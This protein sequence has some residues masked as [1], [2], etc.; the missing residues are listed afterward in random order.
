VYG[1]VGSDLLRGRSPDGSTGSYGLQ[2]QRA[3]LKWVKE[4]VASFGG[5]P[6]RVTIDGCSA[7]AGSTINHMVNQRSWPYFHQAAAA[8]GALAEWNVN[9][10]LQAETLFDKLIGVTGCTDVDCLVNLSSQQLSTAALQAV[11]KDTGSY[12]NNALPFAPVID[13]IEI[14]DTPENLSA[15][16]QLFKGPVLLGTARQ[17]VCSLERSTPPSLIDVF[18]TS[19][20]SERAM[21]VCSLLELNVPTPT[22]SDHSC[23]PPSAPSHAN[24]QVSSKPHPGRVHR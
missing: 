23:F 22:H 4:N 16:G 3:A 5:D 19:T 20:L 1:F 7:G 17:E 12:A 13:G 9:T 24:S 6:A 2:D 21:V 10:M 15:K 11:G 14:L 8:S 18:S